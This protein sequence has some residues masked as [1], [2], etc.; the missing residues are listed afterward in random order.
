MWLGQD[1]PFFDPAS[2]KYVNTEKPG[3]LE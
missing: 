2:F 1:T 3:V